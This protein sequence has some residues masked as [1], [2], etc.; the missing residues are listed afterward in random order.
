M[1]S[2]P[3]TY[4]FTSDADIVVPKR[5]S[6]DFHKTLR[7]VGVQT[8]LKVYDHG[9]HGEFALGFK[10]NPKPLKVFHRDLIE[11]LHS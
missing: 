10:K 2:F 9:T 4:L 3:T 5:E 11:L 1:T 7:K 6:E 8:D